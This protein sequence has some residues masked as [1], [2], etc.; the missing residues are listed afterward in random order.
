MNNDRSI[1]FVLCQFRSGLEWVARD[2]ANMSRKETLIDIR[3]G[4]LPTVLQ[5]LECNPC[6]HLCS[7]VTDDED[8]AEAIYYAEHREKLEVA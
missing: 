1:F 6:E 7:D 8:F 4:E 3:S 2:P 5:V